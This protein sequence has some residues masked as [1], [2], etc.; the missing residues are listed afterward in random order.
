MKNQIIDEVRE[1]RAA[2][3][4]ELGYDRQRI[5]EWAR[6]THSAHMQAQRA[7]SPHKSPETAGG[8][9]ESPVTRKRRRRPSDVSA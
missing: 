2:L 8:A 5:Y 4:A 1:A 3:A 7:P 6:A 9:E